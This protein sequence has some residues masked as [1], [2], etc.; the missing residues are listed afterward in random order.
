MVIDFLRLCRKI[1]YMAGQVQVCGIHVDFLLHFLVA[2]TLALV[3][4]KWLNPKKTSFFLIILI[5]IKE[6][7]DIFAKSRIEYIR[8]P[9]LD[10]VYDV[11]AGIAGLWLGLALYSRFASRTMKNE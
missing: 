7:T 2:F 8:P 11:T 10:L 6:L 3:L 1:L 9:G 5:A 4:R